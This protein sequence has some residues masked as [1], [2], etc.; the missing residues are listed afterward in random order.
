M[1][2]RTSHSHGASL[3]FIGHI[4]I[5]KVE[6]LHGTRI[7]PGGGALYAALAAKTLNVRSVLVSAIGKDFAYRDCF[8]GLDTAGIKTLSMPTTRFHIRYN[9]NWDAN[10]LKA[11]ASAG[12]RIAPSQIPAHALTPDSLIHIAPLKPAKVLKILNSVRRRSPD[13]QISISTWLGYTRQPRHRKLLAQLASQVDFFILNEFEAKALTQTSSLS[14]AL[15]RLETDKLIVT[16]GK[17]GAII[18]GSNIEPQMIPATL[19]PRRETV[20]TTGAGDTWNG[21]FLATYVT[22]HDLMKSVT[23][24]SVI[25]SI[26]CQQWGFK[27]LRKLTFRNPGDV[28]EYVLALKEGGM[29]KKITQF[30]A[31]PSQPGE[32]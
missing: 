14:F 21:A 13:T 5:D 17:L 6:N 10:Y 16:M 27:A 28:V 11:S 32:Q 23:V 8:Q 3:T 31:N 9:E 19:L 18:S 22:T 24:A 2:P 26:K 20:D 30:S 7:Q 12:A 1:S 29:Q 25:S 15:E 4:S